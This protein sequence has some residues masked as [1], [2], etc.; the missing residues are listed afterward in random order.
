[1]IYQVVQEHFLVLKTLD[2]LIES[3]LRGDEGGLFQ[4]L[5]KLLSLTVQILLL[6]LNDQLSLLL[7][8]LFGYRFALRVL[9]LQIIILEILHLLHL[10]D[11]VP[12][13]LVLLLGVDGRV[14]F[15]LEG[16]LLGR[17]VEREVDVDLFALVV[18]VN[19]EP[20]YHFSPLILDDE[21][22]FQ[23]VAQKRVLFQLL[24]GGLVQELKEG[25][26]RE[27]IILLAHSIPL[28]LLDLDFRHFF[29]LGEFDGTQLQGF[30]VL[31]HSLLVFLVL[32]SRGLHGGRPEFL[33]GVF[34]GDFLQ[35]HSLVVDVQVQ[36]SVG[37]LLLSP[38]FLLLL[39]LQIVGQS[40]LSGLSE[41]LELS[42][43]VAGRVVFDILMHLVLCRVHLRSPDFFLTDELTVSLLEVGISVR[44]SSADHFLHLA[45]SPMGSGLLDDQLF[46]LVL[47]MNVSFLS[48]PLI[49]FEQ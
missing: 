24:F 34:D 6:F 8:S 47:K 31:Q 19:V 30:S 21:D 44:L 2:L 17:E 39:V 42:V 29:V 20:P 26:L 16:S 10:G 35:V 9:S 37:A 46:L 43:E 23:V 3:Q 13:V 18:F 1:M 48:F 36:L 12:Q 41:F 4:F 14:V 33:G 28:L 7:L 38:S 25:L 49:V 11:V 15:L 32:G 22:L 27:V 45:L 5:V 40:E